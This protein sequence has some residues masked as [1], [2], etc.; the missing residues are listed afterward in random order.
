MTLSTLVIHREI[1]LSPAIVWDAL[2]DPVLVGGWLG[3]AHIDARAGG[4][5][6]LGWLGSVEYPGV[7]GTIERMSPLEHLEIV[8][9]RH[10]TVGFALEA[11]D[12]GTR[13]TSTRLTVRVELDIAHAFLSRVEAIWAVALDQLDE[14]LRGHPVE[15]ATK[16][17]VDP[18][19]PSQPRLA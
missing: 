12:G 11:Q 16:P 13:G 4:E 9:D 3:D 8:T 14:L 1:D 6:R 18:A 2:V 17:R 15:W 10:G 7:Q 5:Y 19:A